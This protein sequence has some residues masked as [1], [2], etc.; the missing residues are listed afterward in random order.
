M[1]WNYFYAIEVSTT[2]YMSDDK[3]ILEANEAFYRAFESL[4]IETMERV[5]LSDPRIICIHPGW[6]KL[7]GWGPIMASWERIFD[8]IFEMKF[9]VEVIS[10]RSD[11]NLGIAVVDEGLTQSGSEGKLR[12][13]V[14]TTNVFER[15]GDR[16]SM[17]LHHGSPV[18]GASEDDEPVLQ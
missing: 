17:V 16:W 5:W 7:A 10:V 11:G 18:M 9:D 4:N 1:A 14:L 3:A 2:P 6:P 12:T 15:V 13:R 8:N